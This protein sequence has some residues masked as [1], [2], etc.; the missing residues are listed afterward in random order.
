MRK[1]LASAA[2][3]AILA[4][5][6]GASP[7]ASAPPSG[8]IRITATTLT[9]IEAALQVRIQALA[10]KDIAGFQAAI[11]LTRPA[12]RRC[13][14]E[15]FDIASRQGV[16]PIGPKV[17]KVEPYG[18]DYLRAYLVEDVGLRRIYFRRDG[19]RWIVTEPRIDELGGERTTTIAGVKVSYWGI[20]EDVIELIAREAGATLEYAKGYARGPF[21]EPY[22]LRVFPT[23][24]SA[25]IVDCWG[26]A[27]ANFR[28][29]HA[30]LI[31]FHRVWFDGSVAR[32][33][34]YTRD[35]L[36]H[37]ALHYVQDQF[38]HGIALRLDWWLI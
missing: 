10:N 31:G 27:F 36:H 3:A 38:I 18:T 19:D 23:R 29:E 26:V 7:P 25:G 8:P 15:Q 24:E 13:Q 5:C 22:S 4:G 17:V 28:D 35:V 34:D 9:E 33:S 16:A 2:F 21:R 37:E 6:V 20:D 30:P 14:M 11:D 1:A 12:F 32:I